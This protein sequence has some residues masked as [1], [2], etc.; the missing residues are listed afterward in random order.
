MEIQTKVYLTIQTKDSNPIKMPRINASRH[1]WVLIL[2]LSK[3][4][5]DP[6]EM[7]TPLQDCK[8][9]AIAMDSP[10]GS[11]LPLNPSCRITRAAS[12]T[13][14]LRGRKEVTALTALGL[15]ANKQCYRR[16]LLYTSFPPL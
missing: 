8:T 5:A 11:L 10:L 2:V 4:E 12:K 1:R 9:L 16:T 3:N 14:L 15:Q 7:N 6:P 13:H